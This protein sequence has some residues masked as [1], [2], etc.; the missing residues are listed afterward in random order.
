MNRRQFLGN[1]TAL[2]LAAPMGGWVSGCAVPTTR[3]RD[4]ELSDP[5]MDE[6]RQ[7]LT[8][9]RWTS[10]DLVAYYR[11]RIG[12]IDRAGPRLK[13]V[14]ELNPDAERIAADLD[15]ERRAGRTRGPLHGIPILLK[16][17]IDTHDRMMTTAGSLALLGSVAPRDA[18]LVERLRAAGA[19]ILGK[20]NLSEWANFR[21]SQSSSGWSG[22]GGQTRN[23]HVTDRDPSGSSSGSAVAVAANLCAAAVGTETDGSI[24]SPASHCGVVGLK[25][26]V[27][28]ISRSGVI[29]ISSSQDTAGPMA[30]CVADVAALLGALVGEDAQDPASTGSAARGQ[31]DYAQFLSADGL[32]GVR[33][34]VLRAQFKVHRRA[35]PHYEKSLMAIAQC[36]GTL[37]DPVQLPSFG[38]VGAAEYQV[39]LHEFKVGVNAYLANLGPNAP[40]KSLAEVIAFNEREAARELPCF[41]Q[42]TLMKAEATAGLE[43]PPYLA[44]KE[45]CRRWRDDLAAVFVKQG[46]DV[47]VAPTA[48]PAG[49]LDPLLGDHGRGGSSSFAAVAGF[50]SITVPCGAVEGLPVGLSF[51]AGAWQEPKLLAVAYAFEQAT[52][53]RIRPQFRPHLSL[54]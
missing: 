46:V 1:S 42:E 7:G 11:R 12:E 20:T 29:P 21:G 25:P 53:A 37:V 41:G 32:R 15:R 2:A 34:G 8:Q 3:A 24:V 13:S 6:L 5:T 18:F 31:R 16:D 54:G 33:V 28:L 45:R 14:L 38:E 35:D 49:T 47:L 26:T 23:P 48:G 9:G 19:V 40:V 10:V 51:I 27:G 39:L 30:R 50:P 43:A 52:R 17:N 44:A 36:G 4:A 22:R